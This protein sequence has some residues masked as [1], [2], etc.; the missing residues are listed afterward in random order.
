MDNNTLDLKDV[1]ERVQDD[2][3][4]LMELLDIFSEDYTEKREV[5]NELIKENNFEEIRN[6][7][8][9]IK[10]AAGNIS[11]KA[12][13]ATSERIERLA[14]ERNLVTV[15]ELLPELD[16]QFVQLQACIKELKTKGKR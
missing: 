2:W 5:L 6:I 14:E 10:G 16:K 1:L 13:H 12:M 9:S 7:A 3:E 4:L 11:A 15:K 8:H